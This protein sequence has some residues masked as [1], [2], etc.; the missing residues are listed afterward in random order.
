MPRTLDDLGFLQI[1]EEP[2]AFACDG[3]VCA[4][5]YRNIIGFQIIRFSRPHAAD[6]DALFHELAHAVRC[7][8]TLPF[9]SAVECGAIGH[10]GYED[11]YWRALDAYR[12]WFYPCKVPQHPYIP[13]LLPSQASQGT[14]LISEGPECLWLIRTEKE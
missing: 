2:E 12:C 1:I 10:G 11:P 7:N 4:A 9:F 14:S 13:P 8:A 6:Y 5:D 3:F